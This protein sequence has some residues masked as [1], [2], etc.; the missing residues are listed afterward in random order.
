MSDQNN[1]MEAKIHHA[2]MPDLSREEMWSHWQQAALDYRR[3]LIAKDH[4]LTQALSALKCANGPQSGG[5]RFDV[6]IDAVEAAL[7]QG[8][9]KGVQP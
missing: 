6:E 2:P 3:E 1:T 7:Q 8:S 5:Y 4:A 9:L